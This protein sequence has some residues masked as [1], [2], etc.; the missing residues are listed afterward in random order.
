MR[1]KQGAPKTGNANS[2]KKLKSK[3]REIELDKGKNGLENAVCDNSYKQNNRFS[4]FRLSH[5]WESL[6]D[7]KKNKNEVPELQN[8][9]HI[10]R[11]LEERF[12]C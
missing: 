1:D 10:I 3:Q 8:D 9:H 5:F 6:R 11:P 4:L 7:L 2:S 12:A